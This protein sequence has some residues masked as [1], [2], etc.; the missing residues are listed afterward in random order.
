MNLRITTN[1]NLRLKLIT[2][3]FVFG[4]SVQYGISQ[5]IKKINLEEI[6]QRKIRKYIVSRSIDKMDDFSLIHASWTK[7]I[8][9]SNFSIVEKSFFL[10]SDLSDVWE[11]YRHANSIRMWNGKSVRFGLLISKISN[12]VSYTSKT[13]FH[14]IDTGD[15]YFLNLKL[16]K[17]IFNIQVAFE[18]IK[19]DQSKR[20][21]EFS[22]LDNNK[23]LGKQSIQ[24]FDN[25]PG[26]TRIVHRSYF[27]SNSQIRDEIFY[28]YFHKK[29]IREFH[30]NMSHLLPKSKPAVTVLK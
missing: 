26:R 22:Y 8:I 27:R 15:V 9:E 17:G 23:S 2:L 20:I 13:L 10:N 21:M 30:K 18:I 16:L 19:I 29:F 4:F 6:P 5:G 3:F 11:C 7:G 12:T 1:H 14:E 28:P 25:G 24:F